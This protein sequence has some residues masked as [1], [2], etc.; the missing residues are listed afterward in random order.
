MNGASDGP[1][2]T[3]TDDVVSA[4]GT[5]IAYRTVGN[6]PPVLVVPGALAVANDFEG[7][8][9]ELAKRFTVHT[10]ERRG[11]GESG[12]QGDDYSIERE[13]EDRAAPAGSHGC[14]VPVRTQL[15]RVYRPGS[16]ARQQGLR[17]GRRLRA[18]RF[19]R[20]F[21]RHEL[22]A[23]LPGAA[24]P[25]P[26]TGRLHHL[27]TCDQ[28]RDDRQGATLDA[29]AHLAGGDQ[30]TGASA[31]VTAP[32]RDR[33]ARTPSPTV[34]TAPSIGIARRAARGDSTSSN[35]GTGSPTRSPSGPNG[36]SPPLVTTS[37]PSPT[38]APIAGRNHGPRR[39]VSAH[40]HTYPIDARNPI[41][42]TPCPAL[43]MSTA[44]VIAL[45]DLAARRLGIPIT[46]PPAR[47]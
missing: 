8:A 26:A 45:C 31:E 13:C 5:A 34:V 6:G 44:G 28:S 10:T 17:E 20:R 15:R 22:G 35:K 12:P 1:L 47:C 38:N 18:G 27:R 29:E 36:Q 46:V 33:A 42:I 25:R 40:H 19:D 32:L 14:H 3:R 4:D 24:C 7:F 43:Q 41:A 21:D 16:R 23:R 39:P 11:R 37:T 2:P 30:K 9:R